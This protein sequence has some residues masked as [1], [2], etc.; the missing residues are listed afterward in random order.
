MS[1]CVSIQLYI[2]INNA[3][4]FKRGVKSWI[5]QNIA[6]AVNLTDLYSWFGVDGVDELPQN[7]DKVSHQTGKSTLFKKVYKKW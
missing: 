5:S 6:T 2:D 7:W 1:N 4:G 3:N